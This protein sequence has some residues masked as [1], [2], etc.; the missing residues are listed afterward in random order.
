MLLQQQRWQG[1]RALHD[2]R[3]DILVSVC[4]STHPLLQEPGHGAGPCPRHLL[5]MPKGKHS[6]TLWLEPA[7]MCQ[8]EGMCNHAKHPG[9]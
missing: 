3:S 8:I 7:E 4:M 9:E 5:I 6:C 1:W 2:D